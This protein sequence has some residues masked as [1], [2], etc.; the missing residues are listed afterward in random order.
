[1][2]T[3]D[4]AGDAAGF[5]LTQLA[6]LLLE[7]VTL[8]AQRPNRAELRAVARCQHFVLLFDKVR[9]LQPFLELFKFEAHKLVRLRL[10]P[11]ER[12]LTPINLFK[13]LRFSC[14]H[15]KISLELWLD[16][17]LRL[18]TRHVHVNVVFQLAFS[19]LRR[20]SAAGAVTILAF[21]VT[22]G[23]VNIFA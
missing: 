22:S 20:L 4:S 1:M 8:F 2:I 9:H 16:R 7:V 23:A 3:Q 21:V 14:L 6:H 5:A 11:Y 13:I 12:G 19:R 18:H 17:N 15:E 10:F